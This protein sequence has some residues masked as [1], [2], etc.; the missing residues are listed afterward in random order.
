MISSLILLLAL[1]LLLEDDDDDDD[2]FDEELGE[3]V[4]ALFPLAPLPLEFAL[5][6]LFELLLPEDPPAAAPPLFADDPDDEVDP[7]DCF[8]FLSLI[9]VLSVFVVFTQFSLNNT[10]SLFFSFLRVCLTIY[11][12]YFAVALNCWRFF[13]LAHVHAVTSSCSLKETTVHILL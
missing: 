9:I 10:F 4:D 1:D 5:L 13:T 7:P 8:S 3:D 2:V 12:N 6:L 11:F